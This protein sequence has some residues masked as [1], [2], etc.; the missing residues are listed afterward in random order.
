MP[1]WEIWWTWR[2]YWTLLYITTLTALL[3]N[4]NDQITDAPTPL[5]DHALAHIHISI[6]IPTRAPTPILTRILSPTHAPIPTYTL[7]P[8]PTLT[9]PPGR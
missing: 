8:A 4:N 6:P 5:S 1:T 2:N 9:P 3:G 7:S